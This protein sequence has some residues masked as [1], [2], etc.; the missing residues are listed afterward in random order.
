MVFMTLT[1]SA[2]I[3]GHLNDRAELID[4]SAPVSII[5]AFRI[6]VES[7]GCLFVELNY[8]HHK[9]YTEGSVLKT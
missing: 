4:F 8:E 2:E 5:A 3:T 6:S 7:Q 1:I 9:H